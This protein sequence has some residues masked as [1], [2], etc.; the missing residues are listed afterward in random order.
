MDSPPVA[1][2]WADTLDAYEV[3]MELGDP[4]LHIGRVDLQ[5]V[6]ISCATIPS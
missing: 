4:L 5:S 1:Q 3:R 2:A 6:Q